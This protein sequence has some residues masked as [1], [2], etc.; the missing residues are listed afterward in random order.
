MS[1]KSGELDI[2][3][4]ISEELIRYKKSGVNNNRKI[5]IEDENIKFKGRSEDES[6]SNNLNTDENEGGLI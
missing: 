2:A 5:T 4:C 3:R 1:N 6:P